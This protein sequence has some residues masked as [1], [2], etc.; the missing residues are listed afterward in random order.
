MFSGICKTQRDIQVEQRRERIERKK[1][2]DSLKRIQ[3]HLHIEPARSPIAPDEPEEEI[4][5]FEDRMRGF[6]ETDFYGQF[7]GSST[8]AP[9]SPPPAPFDTS[10]GGLHGSSGTFGAAGSLV[11]SPPFYPPP[12]PGT[13]IFGAAGF[14]GVTDSFVGRVYRRRPRPVIQLQ[15]DSAA[16]EA[17]REDQ[18]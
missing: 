4:E 5:S 7:F 16:S 15:E 10:F 8:Y 17:I 12:P 2:T 1:N 6:Q 9:S 14:Q 13:G 11:A 18:E 3:E